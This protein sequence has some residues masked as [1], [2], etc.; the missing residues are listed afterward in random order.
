MGRDISYLG[1][2][3]EDLLTDLRE[4]WGYI[5][6]GGWV[7][8]LLMLMIGAFLV[9]D[10]LELAGISFYDSFLTGIKILLS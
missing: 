6:K 9:N 8:L 1:V 5:K 2:E 10:L 7:F 4:G 3:T